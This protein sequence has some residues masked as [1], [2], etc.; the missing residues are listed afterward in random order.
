MKAERKNLV[1][2]IVGAVVLIAAVWFFFLTYK[3]T[4]FGTVEGY[5]LTARFE[6]VDGLQVGNDVRLGGIK[7]G[8]VTSQKIDPET[9]QAV[10]TFNV[11]N[12]VRLPRDTFVSVST[13]GLLGGK[14]LTLEP[15]GEA[16]LLEDGD[17]VEFTQGTVD[18][19]DLI[20]RAIFSDDDGGDE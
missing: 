8:T 9:F 13:E 11:E 1:E 6:R 20:G 2:T 7:I 4:D 12:D 3:T 16:D 15:G 5:Q 17:E 19:V 14:Y 18:V 10:V